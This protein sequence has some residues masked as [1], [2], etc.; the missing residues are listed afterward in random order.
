[1]ITF[2]VVLLTFVVPFWVRLIL[3]GLNILLP[4]MVPLVDEIL[5]A[6]AVFNASPLVK[7]AK[8]IKTARKLKNKAA[9]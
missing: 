3:L 6:Y 4:D 2:I 9:P 5:Q 7:G 8:H 1:M